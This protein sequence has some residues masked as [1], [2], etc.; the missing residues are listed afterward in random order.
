MRTTEQKRDIA[1]ISNALLHFTRDERVAVAD[2]WSVCGLPKVR[3]ASAL[4]TLAIVGRIRLDGEEA[5]INPNAT[6][7]DI[8]GKRH[9]FIYRV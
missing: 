9:Y 1:S 5:G 8:N 6:F 3:L 2:V 7:V 4:R